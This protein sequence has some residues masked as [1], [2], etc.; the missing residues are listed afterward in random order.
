MAITL[1]DIV[2]SDA[3]ASMPAGMRDLPV[4]AQAAHVV[5]LELDILAGK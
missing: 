5:A 1:G 4:R 2:W 3:D